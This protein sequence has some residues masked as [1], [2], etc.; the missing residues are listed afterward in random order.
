MDSFIEGLKSLNSYKNQIKHI[1]YLPPKKGEYGTLDSPLPPSIQQYLNNRQIKLYKHQAD[2]INLAR[3]GENVKHF[4]KNY[5]NNASFSTCLVK[6][7]G[8]QE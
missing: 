8:L 7:C 3:K 5:V 1:E 2:A 4:Y 6:N